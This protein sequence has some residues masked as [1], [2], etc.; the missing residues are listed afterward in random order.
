MWQNNF[1]FAWIDL[2]CT[3]DFRICFGKTFVSFD[4]DEQLTQSIA[5]I[6]MQYH[7]SKDCLRLHLVFHQVLSISGYD[8]ENGRMLR[9][10][11]KYWIKNIAIKIP[12]LILFHFC[13][14]WYLSPFSIVTANCFNFMDPC[15][16]F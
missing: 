9:C 1:F 11:E 15:R 14:L 13:L 10:K 2:S 5:Q 6:T 12:I 4:F 16:W 3:F 7:A 8:L